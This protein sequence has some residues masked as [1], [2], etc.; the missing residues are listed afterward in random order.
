MIYLNGE[1]LNI[2]K[3]PNG[4]SLIS[5]ENLKVKANQLNNIKIK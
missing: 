5:S 3:F 1:K 4:E 2:I